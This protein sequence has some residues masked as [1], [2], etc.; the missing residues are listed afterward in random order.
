MTEPAPE[1][2]PLSE[3]MRVEVKHH[4]FVFVLAASDATMGDIRETERR[5][6]QHFEAH[7]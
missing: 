2:V 5:V 1:K 3:V 7:Y 4:V 6:R